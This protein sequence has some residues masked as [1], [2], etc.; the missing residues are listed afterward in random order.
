MTEQKEGPLLPPADMSPWMAPPPP[1]P[2]PPPDVDD[3]L[4]A[5]LGGGITEASMRRALKKTGGNQTEAAKL[6][7][8]SRDKFRWWMKKY[9][10][11]GPDDE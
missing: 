4:L 1:A 7:G 5:G 2:E 3:F 10:I 8:I 6:L 9:G 11:E